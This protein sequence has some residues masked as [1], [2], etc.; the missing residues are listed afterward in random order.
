MA[1]WDPALVT[2]R[3]KLCMHTKFRSIAPKV[4]LAKVPFLASFITMATFFRT[5]SQC[6]KLGP[7]L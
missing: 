1:R 3:V 4:F 6:F 5:F 2:F 7:N